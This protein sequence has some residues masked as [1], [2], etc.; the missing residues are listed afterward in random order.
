MSCGTDLWVDRS[1]TPRFCLDTQRWSITGL[2]FSASQAAS[3]PTRRTQPALFLGPTVAPDIA[4]AYEAFRRDEPICEI[5]MGSFTSQEVGQQD[6]GAGS[7]GH[8]AREINASL[9]QPNT[10]VE[11]PCRNASGGRLRLL[12]DQS[13]SRIGAATCSYSACSPVSSLL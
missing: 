13:R 9:G 7:V 6:G 5:A 11:W 4:T 10:A 12:V 3:A 8:A 2:W 1:Q